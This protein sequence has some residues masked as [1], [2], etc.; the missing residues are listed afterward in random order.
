[1]PAGENAKVAELEGQ[2][3]KLE[4]QIVD[5]SKK[6]AKA[7]EENG[8][9]EVAK[10]L[11]EATKALTEASEALEKLTKERDEAVAIA[12]LSSEER[13]YCADM[14]ADDRSA[15]MS[16]SPEDRKKDMAK[17]AEGDESV[18]L[19]GATIKKSVVGEGV[20]A[21][22]KSQSEKQAELAKKLQEEQ[23]IRKKAEFEKR[24]DDQFSH[25]PGTT[26]ERGEMLKAMA[27]M[28][29][30]IRKSFEKVFEQSEKLAKA[31]FD[32]IG[33]SDSGKPLD[34]SVK[35]ATM[36][37]N[38][39]VSEIKKRDECNSQEA[40]TKARKEYPELFKLYQGEQQETN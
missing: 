4:A 13:E 31:G 37:F 24:A 3:T 33:S 36:D 10:E 38:A 19:D 8:S 12:K 32:K 23:D 21:I 35:K 22:L 40:M 25:V 34:P 11:E 17:K 18:T 26:Q 16:K 39:K 14:S 27:D 1:M 5:L 29:E 7:Q 15:F 20:F 2:V 6:L 9:T 30:A 28:P